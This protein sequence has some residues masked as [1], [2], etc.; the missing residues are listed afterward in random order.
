MENWPTYDRKG[1]IHS[2]AGPYYVIATTFVLGSLHRKDNFG[3]QRKLL[4]HVGMA[5]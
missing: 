3:L 4:A 1:R 2:T 5:Q